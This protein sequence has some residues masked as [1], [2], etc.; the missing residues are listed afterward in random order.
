MASLALGDGIVI[1]GCGAILA[2]DMKSGRLRWASFPDWAWGWGYSGAAI[3]LD[4][5][6]FIGGEYIYALDGQTGVLRW[7]FENSGASNWNVPAI[8]ADGTVYVG[9]INTALALDGQTGNLYGMI[10]LNGIDGTIYFGVG[11]GL[12][13]INCA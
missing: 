11:N 10:P 6:V 5:T 1:V 7:K 2:L 3:G 9:G 12:V 13:A 8:G 4:G